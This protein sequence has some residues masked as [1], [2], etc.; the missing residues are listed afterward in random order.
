M[1]AFN[2]SLSRSEQVFWSA[3]TRRRFNNA[4]TSLRTPYKNP[5]SNLSK[6]F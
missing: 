3:V 5:T 4:Q 1:K 2:K 6:G